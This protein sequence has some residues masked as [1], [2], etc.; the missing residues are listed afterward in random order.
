MNGKFAT[1]LNKMKQFIECPEC[2]NVQLIEQY[3]QLYCENCLKVF[4]YDELNTLRAISIRQPWA[5]LIVNGYKDIENRNNLKNFT[6]KFLIHASQKF[7][8]G[9][10]EIISRN[11][12]ETGAAFKAMPAHL[13]EKDSFGKGYEYGGIIGY[14]TI[15]GFVTESYSP[16]FVGKYG[17]LIKDAHPL[18]FTPCKGKLS[19]FKPEIE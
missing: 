3:Q 1:K 6:G 2:G 14:A 7:D 15:T 10:C 11:T 9:W 5:L 19:F 8:F 4:F 12:P 13:T 16:W 18:P 17:L